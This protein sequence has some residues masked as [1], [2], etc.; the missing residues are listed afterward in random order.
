MSVVR[1]TFSY[2]SL[3]DMMRSLA[4]RKRHGE[5]VLVANGQSTTLTIA[6]GLI[7]DVQSSVNTVAERMAERVQVVLPDVVISPL[8]SATVDSVWKLCRVRGMGE[9]KTKSYYD[10]AR[11]DV[12][13]DLCRLDEGAYRFEAKIVKM[14][15]SQRLNAC[16]GRVLLDWTDLLSFSL[17]W[18]EQV[19]IEYA[20]SIE[21]QIFFPADWPHY[22]T[23]LDRDIYESLQERLPFGRLKCAVPW[24]KATVSEGLLFLLERELVSLHE[25]GISKSA[26]ADISET[27]VQVVER[28]FSDVVIDDTSEGYDFVCPS[29]EDE[30]GRFAAEEAGSGHAAIGSV[31]RRSESRRISA[32]DAVNFESEIEVSRASSIVEDMKVDEF[33]LVEDSIGND[34]VTERASDVKARLLRLNYNLLGEFRQGTAVH[35]SITIFLVYAAVTVSLHLGNFI[36]SLGYFTSAIG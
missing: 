34:E 18:R 21:Q 16:I 6:G 17:R 23:D 5:L 12:I 1:G 10:A 7:D 30:V 28:M 32:T 22:M 29:G 4:Y 36:R 31:H 24:D 3:S 26:C 20:G 33:V 13:H 11:Y 8:E 35:L 15:E 14:P 27:S 25:I 2:A 9:D 19:G